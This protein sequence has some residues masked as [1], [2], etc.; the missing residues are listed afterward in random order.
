MKKLCIAVLFLFV[1]LPVFAGHNTGVNPIL[2]LAGIE[3]PTEWNRW[4]EMQKH[5]WLQDRGIY[6]ERG[7]KYEGSFDLD[8]YFEFLGVSQPSDWSQKSFSERKTFIE[9]INNSVSEKILLEE[10]KTLPKS[11]ETKTET[12]VSTLSEIKKNTPE[13]ISVST[14]ETPEPVSEDRNWAKI[15]I[16]GV[17]LFFV[18]A[19]LLFQKRKS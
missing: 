17:L 5:D 12:P 3:K 4:R 13:V 15:F 16:F 7:R 19:I 10:A 11:E 2:D 8:R 1:S 14:V 9:N 6:P 18:A